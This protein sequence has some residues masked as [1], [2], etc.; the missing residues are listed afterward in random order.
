M[1]MLVCMLCV[2]F[3]IWIIIRRCVNGNDGNSSPFSAYNCC[4]PISRYQFS[5]DS[6]RPILKWTK[7]STLDVGT[8][9]RFVSII[10]FKMSHETSPILTINFMSIQLNRIPCLTFPLVCAY[11]NLYLDSPTMAFSLSHVSY[12]LINKT[13]N[14]PN[15]QWSRVSFAFASVTPRGLEIA[16]AT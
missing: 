3:A 4:F 9:T 6:K 16:L 13:L 5:A 2:N 10:L 11:L 14:Q 12:M 1:P 15:E 8:L 7:A